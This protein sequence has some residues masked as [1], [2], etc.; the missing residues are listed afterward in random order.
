MLLSLSGLPESS[1]VALIDDTG[2]RSI[3]QGFAGSTRGQQLVSGMAAA[4]AA[5]SKYTSNLSYNAQAANDAA[6]II[7]SWESQ[8]GSE[9]VNLASQGVSRVAD[10]VKLG[11][12]ASA[13]QSFIIAS[14]AKAAQGIPAWAGQVVPKNVGV[15]SE[16]TY[17]DADADS[18]ARLLTFASI[19]KMDREGSLSAI[20]SQSTGASGLGLDP[21]TVAW[22]VGTIA[23]AAIAAFVI[24]KLQ[25]QKNDQY[26][27]ILD[28]WCERDPEGCKQ[29]LAEIAKRGP[30]PDLVSQASTD[31]VKY[32][33]L[34]LLA[35]VGV[36]YGLPALKKASS[37]GSEH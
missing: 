8:H 28:R 31:V 36:V 30:T 26:N 18:E 34:A 5:L 6:A 35:Y 19:V 4:R 27:A 22:V 3:A 33:G 37:K 9:L 7:S 17:V 15:T 12:S 21:V 25:E 16:Y 11:L 1:Q 14:Y 29:G 32:A 13:A 2:I 24:L 10:E 23:V 20:F